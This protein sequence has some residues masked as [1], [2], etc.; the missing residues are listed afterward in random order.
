M[1]RKVAPH[2]GPRLRNAWQARPLGLR[3]LD[4]PY[5]PPIDAQLVV[6]A[7]P[8]ALSGAR[9]QQEL[10]A[11]GARERALN[12][13]AGGIWR[14]SPRRLSTPTEFLFF[15]A[16]FFL[17]RAHHVLRAPRFGSLAD[18][19]VLTPPPPP[20]GLRFTQVAE[21]G[22]EESVSAASACLLQRRYY[23]HVFLGGF[24]GLNSGPHA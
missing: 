10:R 16:V 7:R 5:R 9:A 23:K 17:P 2:L 14:L 12:R 20:P 11:R 22:L 8:E 6:P 1:S 19:S 13:R 15:K 3:P 21:D 24:S 4:N 18:P